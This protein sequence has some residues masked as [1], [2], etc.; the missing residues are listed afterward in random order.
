M[1][2]DPHGWAWASR[3]LRGVEDV[4]AAAVFTVA[5][6]ALVTFA[7]VVMAPFPQSKIVEV[8][9]SPSKDAPVRR[10]YVY[11]YTDANGYV[12]I[13][14][15]EYEGS[16]VETFRQAIGVFGRLIAVFDV[17][18]GGYRCQKYVPY[19]V[20]LG[21]DPYN[22]LWCPPPFENKTVAGCTPIG[23]TSRGRWLQVQ[24]RCS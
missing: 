8:P 12:Q 14:A 19:P 20:K 17:Y 11:N 16:D 3:K 13:Y 22:G 9:I 1:S 6:A 5:T 24:Y 7:V 15:I 4:V 21:E 10:V 18:P 23:L 2:R